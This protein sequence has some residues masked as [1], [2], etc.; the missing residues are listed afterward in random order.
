MWWS[1]HAIRWP[2]F[3]TA[4]PV[5]EITK[6]LAEQQKAEAQFAKDAVTQQ[7]ARD[8][9]FKQAKDAKKQ[10]FDVAFKQVAAEEETKEKAA[11]DTATKAAHAQRDKVLAAINKT[12]SD[13]ERSKREALET[14]SAR[15]TEA[16][17]G[18]VACSCRY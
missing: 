9:A 14:G 5:L 18:M 15:K 4:A 16:N 2:A 12:H 17:L 7:T 8:V 3:L 6:V 10:E 1:V 13:Q 11:E